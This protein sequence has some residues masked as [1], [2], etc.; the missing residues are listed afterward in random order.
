MLVLSLGVLHD[1]TEQQQ[2]QQPHLPRTPLPTKQKQQLCLQPPRNNNALAA[3]VA[4]LVANL[5]IVS[6]LVLHELV[7]VSSLKKKTMIQLLSTMRNLLK[8]KK[9]YIL[10]MDS[11]LFYDDHV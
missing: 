1:R 10:I 4:S 7:A 5:A 11:F 3:Y 8:K 9:K 6:M 2:L